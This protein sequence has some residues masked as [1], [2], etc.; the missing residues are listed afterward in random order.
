MTGYMRLWNPT[1]YSAAISVDEHHKKD[2][3]GKY[4]MMFEIRFTGSGS[5]TAT[6][7]GA[8][9]DA[10]L[11]GTTTPVILYIESAAAGDTIA[12]AGVRRVRLIGITVASAQ[13]YLN[14]KE[15]PVYSLE[16]VNM[17]TSAHVCT[18]RYY[19][20]VIHAYASDWG[21]NKDADGNITVGDD[22]TPTTT[23]LT[24]AAGSNESNNG[25]LIYVAEGFHG[26]WKRLLLNINDPAIN[27][28]A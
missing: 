25:G 5:A 6:E 9:A 12:G 23:Y 14:G 4:P 19:L 10:A 22:A 1:W 13:A 15:D 8:A 26:R 11:N 24:I 17:A 7:I 2:V 28:G 18:V 20:R 3:H 27:A 16:E 21:A